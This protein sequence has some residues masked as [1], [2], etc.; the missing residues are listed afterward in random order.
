MKIFNVKYT[1]GHLIDTSTKKRIFLKRG[2]MFNISGEESCFE[3]K[4][5][6]LID[7]EK[8][9]PKAKLESLKKKYKNYHLEKVADMER[10][11]VYRVG[12]SRKTNE[13]KVREYHFNAII[14]ED[15]YLRS[16]N[17]LDWSLCDCLCETTKCIDGGI[18]MFESVTGNSLNNLY[19]NMITFYFRMQRSSTCNVFNTFYLCNVI[20]NSNYDYNRSSLKLLGM[21][22]D[23]IRNNFNK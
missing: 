16:K 20:H 9:D 2:S 7:K 8:L 18:Q 21:I 3:E 4:D 13:D 10:E 6:L 1:K 15:L 17:G 14:L 11:F 12:L 19:S 23:N 5:D 22:R